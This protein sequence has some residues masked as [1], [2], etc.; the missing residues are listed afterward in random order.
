MRFV[1]NFVTF[2]PLKLFKL[3]SQLTF[4]RNLSIPFSNLFSIAKSLNVFQRILCRFSL[5]DPANRNGKT[6]T[7]ESHEESRLHGFFSSNLSVTFCEN[8]TKRGVCSGHYFNSHHKLLQPFPPSS[9]WF[10]VFFRT[11][12]QRRQLLL[13]RKSFQAW[14]WFWSNTSL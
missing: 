13:D 10:N 2:S 12:N 8:S 5:W 1:F 6:W 14:F 7:N 4:V 3:W 11:Q 9:D